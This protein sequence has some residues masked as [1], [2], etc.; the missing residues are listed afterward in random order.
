MKRGAYFAHCG[1]PGVVIEDDML[2]ALAEGQLGGGAIDCYTY[3]PLRPDDPLVP[4]ERVPSIN[5]ILTPHDAA[6]TVAVSREERVPD[7]A[8]IVR[9]L[10]GET[11]SHRLV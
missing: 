5:L 8:N 9:V 6:G 10:K 4:V 2:R 1:A 3:E 7:F 11:V